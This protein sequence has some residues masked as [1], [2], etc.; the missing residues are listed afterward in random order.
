MKDDALFGRTL[1]KDTSPN[2]SD[3]KLEIDPEKEVIKIKNFL[4]E[5]LKRL[6]RQN[7]VIGLSGGLDSTTACYLAVS[8]LGKKQVFGLLL[9]EKDSSKENLEDA[10]NVAKTLGIEFK[11]IDISPILEEIGV[12]KLLRP[13][14]EKKINFF[15]LL[16]KIF[17]NFSPY[18]LSQQFR[19]GKISGFQ[20]KFLEKYSFLGSFLLTKVRL[21]M[22]FLYYYAYLKNA[23]VL[24]TTDKTE[25]LLG[26]YDKYGDGAHDI[27]IFKHLYKSQIREIAKFLGVPEKIYKKLPDPD[28]FPGLNEEA[29]LGLPIDLVDKIL[30][31]LENNIPDK[32]IAKILSIKPR[33]VEAIKK[34]KFFANF[35]REMPRSLLE[36]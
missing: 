17:P 1:S 22:I 27:S 14:D 7:L 4:Q 33:I 23:L 26:F 3:L 24:G 19:C 31:G 18:L 16:K 13:Q 9:P 20:K 2:L 36:G 11:E 5:E 25:W 29:L 8:A 21:R 32:K 30:V 10:R 12:Y 28:L 34:S 15:F 35:E 6:N